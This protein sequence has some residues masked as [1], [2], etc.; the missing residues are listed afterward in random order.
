[1]NYDDVLSEM[2]VIIDK[3]DIL[4]AK[5]EDMKEGIIKKEFENITNELKKVINKLEMIID[6]MN[7]SNEKTTLEYTKNSIK[8]IKND[9]RNESNLAII[10][11]S[12][13]AEN[14]TLIKVKAKISVN[15]HL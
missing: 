9:L 4:I 6:S 10:I 2:G 8:K 15:E 3:I 14:S 11:D 1:M 7:D 12:L 13:N 5:L